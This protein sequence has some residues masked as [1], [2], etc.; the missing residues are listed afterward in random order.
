MIRLAAEF[1]FLCAVN[2]S[3]PTI[4]VNEEGDC[5]AM[6]EANSDHPHGCYDNY[7]DSLT[8]CFDRHGHSTLCDARFYQVT[9]DDYS[10]ESQTTPEPPSNHPEGGQGVLDTTP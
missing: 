7:G 2:S 9:D 8:D 5:V 6:C 10:I 3:H 4:F 1:F